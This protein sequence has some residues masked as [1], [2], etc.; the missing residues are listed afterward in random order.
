MRSRTSPDWKTKQLMLCPEVPSMVHLNQLTVPTLI[1]L[2][3]IKEEVENDNHLKE[4]IRRIG[5]GE[6]VQK[7]TLQQDML[8]YKGRLVIAKN[9]TLIPTILH[10]YHDSV[11]GVT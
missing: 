1:D 3:V 7:Y 11:L 6:E 5:R 8:Q 9:S 2:K 10:T 4:I